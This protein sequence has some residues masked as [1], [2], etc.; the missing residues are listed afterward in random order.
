MG[1]DD[2]KTFFFIGTKLEK[3]VPSEGTLFLYYWGPSHSDNS[4]SV[5]AN[6]QLS[7]VKALE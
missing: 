2:G 6:V 7:H 1:I 3:T 4:G 5:I